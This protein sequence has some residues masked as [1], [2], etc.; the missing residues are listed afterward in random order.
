MPE[1]MEV[2]KKSVGTYQKDMGANLKELSM[3]KVRTCRTPNNPNKGIK[4]KK[5]KVFESY[6]K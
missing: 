4:T 6:L 2:Q 3:V 1:N 5:P